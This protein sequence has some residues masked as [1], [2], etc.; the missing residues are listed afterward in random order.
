MAKVDDP[1]LANS[2]VSHTPLLLCPAELVLKVKG[3]ASLT[4]V[5]FKEKEMRSLVH[6]FQS[7]EWRLWNLPLPSNI[8]SLISL[9]TNPFSFLCLLKSLEPEIPFFFALYIF[10]GLQ[11]ILSAAIDGQ[12]GGV[13]A[14]SSWA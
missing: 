8:L 14:G 13:S 1:K 5:Q 7:G 3:L 6:S 4:P 11:H 2:E 9:P 12:G 10:W